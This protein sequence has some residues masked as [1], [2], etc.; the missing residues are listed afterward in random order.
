LVQFLY[1]KEG[2]N[3]VGR[4]SG[5]HQATIDPLRDYLHL[6]EDITVSRDYDSILRITKE[7]V[8]KCRLCIDPISNPTDALSM[9]IHL[10]HAIL[11]QDG[12]VGTSTPVQELRA[13]AT[14]YR[15]QHLPPLS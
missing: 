1:G 12:Q 8:I 6:E 3:N 13:R 10:S 5:E 14:T 9:S 2:V 11:G 15:Q 7:I 4:S